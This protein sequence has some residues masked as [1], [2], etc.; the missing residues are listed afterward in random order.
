MGDN[1]VLKIAGVASLLSVASI[2]AAIV[3]GIGS[4]GGGP[5]A[6]DFGDPSVLRSMEAGGQ[7]PVLLSLLALIGPSVSL[8]AGL[9]WH[10]LLAHKGSYVL[11]GVVLWYLGM[12]F[13]IWQ[14]AAELTLIAHLPGAYAA[15][16]GAQAE[17]LLAAGGLMGH[18]IETFIVLGD[19]IS[20]FGLLLVNLAM[21]TLG[22][23]WRILAAIGAA[24]CVL[25][26]GGVA[27]PVLAPAR[28]PGFVLFVSWMTAMGIAMLRTR[29]A[30]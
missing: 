16:D 26:A 18:A 24:S 10:R 9:G 30:A 20:F 28:L 14:D 22:G 19:V 1:S 23:K 15:A 11:V 29:P 12:I 8:P 4:G 21:W 7:V 17:A 5:V 25:I 2:A 27:L 13:V 6:I 3:I